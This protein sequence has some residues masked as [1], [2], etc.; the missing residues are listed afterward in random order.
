MKTE[1]EPPR[2]LKLHNAFPQ[3]KCILI[4][5]LLTHGIFYFAYAHPIKKEHFLYVIFSNEEHFSHCK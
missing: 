1:S 5:T 4:H 2:Y 3:F